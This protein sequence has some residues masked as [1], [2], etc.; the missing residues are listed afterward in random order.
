MTGFDRLALIDWCQRFK[1]RKA[2]LAASLNV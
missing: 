1:N 2:A